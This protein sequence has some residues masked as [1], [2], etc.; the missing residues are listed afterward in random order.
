MLVSLGAYA[1]RRGYCYPSQATLA[2][3]LKVSRQA[4]N[5]QIHILQELGYLRIVRRVH[6]CGAVLSC[7]YQ[8]LFESPKEE[9]VNSYGSSTPFSHQQEQ[10]GSM[11]AIEKPYEEI[12]RKNMDML[13]GA[14]T[15]TPEVSPPETLSVSSPSTPAVSPPAMSDV[16]Q[17]PQLTSQLTPQLN[18]GGIQD[19]VPVWST[20][21]Q[22][23]PEI[24]KQ[25]LKNKPF[26][27]IQV[28]SGNNSTQRNRV[29][30]EDIPVSTSMAINQEHPDL[31]LY[32]SITGHY[33]SP[34]EI[35]SIL[36]VMQNLRLNYAD[37]ISLRT[38]LESIWGRWCN[39]RRSNGTP[40]NRANSAWLTDWAFNAS[41]NAHKFHGGDTLVTSDARSYSTARNPTPEMK[42]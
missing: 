9:A 22:K 2:S 8:I 36:N 18:G 38:Y 33:P 16:A 39:T 29:G 4:V 12:Q 30:R 13:Q 42:R 5:R 1:D 7:L 41:G 26:N 19:H 23:I 17:T 14:R 25:M 20:T 6:P 24:K 34:W 3:R 10:S 37:D 28:I 27:S 35:E 11:I 31:R 32:R 21:T 15:A 40:Y